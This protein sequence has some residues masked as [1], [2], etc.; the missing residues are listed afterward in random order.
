MATSINKNKSHQKK[1]VNTFILFIVIVIGILIVT[2]LVGLFSNSIPEDAAIFLIIYFPFMILIGYSFLNLLPNK[3][4]FIPLYAAINVLFILELFLIFY[5]K[6]IPLPNNEFTF[7]IILFISNLLLVF[8]SYKMLEKRMLLK[9]VNKYKR[10]IRGN[11]NLLEDTYKL[12]LAYKRLEKF[13]EATHIFKEAIRIKPDFA[14]AYFELGFCSGIL[15][16]FTEAA[17]AFKKAIEIKPDFAEAHYELGTTYYLSKDKEA[18]IKEYAILKDLN[19][20][21]AKKLREFMDDIDKLYNQGKI[22]G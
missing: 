22:I 12:G 4:I 11:P 6:A 2:F 1:S 16:I 19:P 8:F 21:L 5:F 13:K 3:K 14:E 10:A 17:D 20:Q 18:T 7:I 15:G 9:T